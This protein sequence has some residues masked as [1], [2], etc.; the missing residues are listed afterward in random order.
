MTR[1]LSDRILSKLLV[2]RTLNPNLTF[3]LRRRNDERLR[4]GYWFLGNQHYI[5]IGLVKRNDWRNRTKQVGLVCNLADTQN[6]RVYLEVVFRSEKKITIATFYERL[7]VSFNLQQVGD[8]RCYRKEY[9]VVDVFETVCSFFQDNGDWSR[10]LQEIS[11]S[12]V[13]NDLLISNDDFEISLARTMDVRRQ[14][15]EGGRNG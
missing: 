11:A 7:I 6:P 9:P 15:K 12:A 13:K 2:L 8:G 1:E 3:W 10:I 14:I 5:F 4:N